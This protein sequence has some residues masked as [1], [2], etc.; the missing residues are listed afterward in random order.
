MELLQNRRYKAGEIPN[1]YFHEIRTLIESMIDVCQ[2]GEIS[3]YEAGCI[4]HKELL[5]CYDYQD[6]LWKELYNI[7]NGIVKVTDYN[8][9]ITPYDV[10]CYGNTFSFSQDD[11][12]ALNE[13][14]K[15]W[16]KK[17][18]EIAL[19][20]MENYNNFLIEAQD[21]LD[22]MF[23]SINYQ[24]KRKAKIKQQI[25]KDGLQLSPVITD[26]INVQT[27]QMD[28]AER[29]INILIFQFPEFA[30]DYQLLKEHAFLEKQKQGYTGRNQ[31]NHW[32]NT[33]M[34]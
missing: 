13:I 31:N 2:E 9:E 3:V 7:E 20:D 10:I 16:T 32:Q 33:L 18:L 14:D 23:E 1:S 15:E 6:E 17:T 8:D 4:I 26:N 21:K 22:K 25:I 11:L 28:I 12:A 29:S 27:S 5:S 19:D 30:K 34:T 24:K